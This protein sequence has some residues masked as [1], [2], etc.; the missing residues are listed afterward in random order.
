MYWAIWI[1]GED[2]TYLVRSE[3]RSQPT[4]GDLAVL[5]GFRGYRGLRVVGFRDLGVC[6]FS[7]LGLRGFRVIRFR[8]SRDKGV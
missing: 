1:P 3:S 8:G 5:L 4:L 7:G 2:V 6:G